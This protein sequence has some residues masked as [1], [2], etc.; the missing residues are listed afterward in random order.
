MK[1]YKIIMTG[2]GSA[3]HV[4]PNLALIPKLKQEGFEVKYIG[5]KNGIERKIIEQENIPYFAIQSGKLRRYF[6]LKNFSDPFKVLKGMVDAVKIIRKEKPDIVFSKGGFVSVPVVMA[7]KLNRIPVIAHECDM[8]PGL[9]NKISTPFCNKVCV[10]FPETLPY[11]KGDKGIVTGL[12]IREEL[13]QGKREEGYRICG[14]SG[15]KPVLLVIGGS[16]GSVIINKAIRESIYKLLENFNIIHICGKG[17]LDSSMDNIKGYKQFEYVSEEL[18]HFMNTADYFIS[19]AGANTIFEILALKKPH[20]LVP[21][22]QKA[23]RGDQILNANSFEKMGYSMVIKEEDLNKEVL[24]EKLMEL[25]NNKKTYIDNME[26]SK[27]V[28]AVDDIVELI[29]NYALKK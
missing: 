2:G 10:T 28:K 18:K 8:T 27:G 12:P 19:R 22:S 25:K 21:L 13:F 7:A 26:Q 24:F 14:F 29:K 23:S 16:L 1:K 11:I 6:D 20:I 9:A 4:T 3:G 5:S 17:N 15:E